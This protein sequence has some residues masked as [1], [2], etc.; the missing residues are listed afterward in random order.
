[1]TRSGLC[2]R[3]LTGGY[4]GGRVGEGQGTSEDRDGPCL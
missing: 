2:V 3:Q 1:M 4:I